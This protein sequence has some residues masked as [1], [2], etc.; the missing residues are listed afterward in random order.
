[1][2]N[3]ALRGGITGSAFF[4]SGLV[5]VFWIVMGQLDRD[6]ILRVEVSYSDS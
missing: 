2:E 1:M 6:L 3:R 4:E 5:L